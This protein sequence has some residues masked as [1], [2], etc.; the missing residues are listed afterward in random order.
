EFPFVRL[1][2]RPSLTGF[3]PNADIEGNSH[4]GTV[5][6]SARQPWANAAELAMAMRLVPCVD[7]LARPAIDVVA[8]GNRCALGSHA[9]V[10]NA[11]SVILIIGAIDEGLSPHAQCAPSK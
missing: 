2:P 8:I 10:V 11:V 5:T 4:C 7:R 1:S 6:R 3:A 9:G